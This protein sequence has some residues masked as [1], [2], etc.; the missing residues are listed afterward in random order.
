VQS[1]FFGLPAIACAVVLS[2]GAPSPARAD[3]ITNSMVE[4][5]PVLAPQ[6]DLRHAENGVSTEGIVIGGRYVACSVARTPLTGTATATTFYVTGDNRDARSATTCSLVSYDYTGAFLGSTSF[7]NSSAHYVVALP[8]P[9]AQLGF[10]AYTSMTCILPERNTATLESVV[11]VQ[12][13]Q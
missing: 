4:C 9:L 12:S 5:Q 11:A 10:W 1:R 2:G 6:S 8:L 7:S 3:S 13:P